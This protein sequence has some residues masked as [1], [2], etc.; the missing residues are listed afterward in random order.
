MYTYFSFQKTKKSPSTAAVDVGVLFESKGKRPPLASKSFVNASA[1]DSSTPSSGSPGAQG[2]VNS[3]TSTETSDASLMGGAPRKQSQEGEIFDSDPPRAETDR[4][5]SSKEYPLNPFESSDSLL[6]EL[7]GQPFEDYKEPEEVDPE[8]SLHVIYSEASSPLRQY[9]VQASPAKSTQTET[10]YQSNSSDQMSVGDGASTETIVPTQR[11]SREPPE[12]DENSQTQMRNYSQQP[13]HHQNYYKHDNYSPGDFHNPVSKE[14]STI[15]TN[16]ARNIMGTP[17]RRNNSEEQ[18]VAEGSYHNAVGK[19]GYFTSRTS[20]IGRHRGSTESGSFREP[21]LPES[22]NLPS[23][24]DHYD[25][26][27]TYI[28]SSPTNHSNKILQ[29]QSNSRRSSAQSHSAPE[30]LRSR[31]PSYNNYV[32]PRVSDEIEIERT[33]PRKQLSRESQRSRDNKRRSR[34]GSHHLERYRVR[35]KSPPRRPYNPCYENC[36]CC[37][38][39][40]YESRSDNYLVDD[41]LSSYSESS[42]NTNVM[43]LAYQHND[44]YLE[45]VQEL[46]DTLSQRNKERVRRTMREFEIM[47]RQ[48]RNLEKPIF[49]DEEPIEMPKPS[50]LHRHKHGHRGQQRSNPC[51]CNNQE[52]HYHEM[53]PDM[54]QRH[55]REYHPERDAREHYDHKNP[56]N[57][58]HVENVVRN[59]DPNPS[60]PEQSRKYPRFKRSQCSTRWQMDQRT[61]EWYKVYDEYEQRASH[62]AR[63]MCE[64]GRADDYPKHLKHHGRRSRPERCYKCNYPS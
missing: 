52:V 62:S 25:R 53:A 63:C 39:N 58:G 8:P 41:D 22:D 64:G 12:R 3:K 40:G 59:M 23:D 34:S 27:L 24:D 15:S 9:P 46:E 2:Y 17:P 30:V 19:E 33:S 6:S 42:K 57:G 11:Y 5:L 47:S 38:C 55:R 50:K 56:A 36:S 18:P 13:I 7:R 37:H 51:Y 35:S 54:D 16:S 60:V 31:E 48:N 10:D 45:L 14:T 49:D 26:N 20:P 21:P 44:E 32:A 4:T 28:R 1:E 29:S 43:D 61:G